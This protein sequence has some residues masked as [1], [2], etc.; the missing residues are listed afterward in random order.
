M[1]TTEKAPRKRKT[2]S[3]EIDGDA[4]AQR[5]YEISLTAE[6]GSDIEYW[7]RAEAELRGS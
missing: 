2:K 3:K 5:A 6:A 1:A 7:L 4:I